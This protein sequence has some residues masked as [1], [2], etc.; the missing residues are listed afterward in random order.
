[1]VGSLKGAYVANDTEE[2]SISSLFGGTIKPEKAVRWS[3]WQ[4]WCISLNRGPGWN[5]KEKH[6]P[7]MQF[8]IWQ[9]FESCWPRNPLSSITLHSYSRTCT[10][11]CW[12]ACSQ[13][14]PMLSW[15]EDAPQWRSRR[16]SLR[17]AVQRCQLLETTSRHCKK[18][19][20]WRAW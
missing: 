10:A 2:L 15:Q 12:P 9:Y 7:M 19:S 11:K 6:W 4:C 8:I 14:A 13:R 5:F 1:M 17:R 16:P 20:E 18:K 3:H